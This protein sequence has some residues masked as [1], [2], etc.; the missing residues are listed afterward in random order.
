ML[1][2]TKQGFPA[3]CHLGA[4]HKVRNAGGG[5]CFENVTVCDRSS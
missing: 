4:V 3:I 5:G 2:L 1:F